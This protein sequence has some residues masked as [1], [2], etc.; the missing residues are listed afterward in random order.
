MLTESGNF[1]PIPQ[2]HVNVTLSPQSEPAAYFRIFPNE[3]ACADNYVIAQHYA[4]SIT[5]LARWQRATQLRRRS[6]TALG[7]MILQP[8]GGVRI[9]EFERCRVGQVGLR[10]TSRAL[11]KGKS[12]CVHHKQSL[13]K[14]QV[15]TV[16]RVTM[17]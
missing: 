11:A 12:S 10:T 16:L 5:A 3:A 8:A 6:M 4:D 1:S 2:S 7:A 17:K 9:Q 13:R 14:R 15:L